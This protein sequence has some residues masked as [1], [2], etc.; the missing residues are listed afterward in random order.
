MAGETPWLIIAGSGALASL[1]WPVA[2]LNSLRECK[3]MTVRFVACLDLVRAVQDT[4][5]NDSDT[6]EAKIT[7]DLS[8]IDVLC[9]DDVAADPTAFESKLLTRILTPATATIDRL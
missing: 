1:I 8:R 7:A 2:A 4:Y 6:T 3:G 5:S 9:L